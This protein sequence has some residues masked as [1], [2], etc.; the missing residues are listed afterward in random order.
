M[1]KLKAFA[2]DR[3]LFYKSELNKAIGMAAHVRQFDFHVCAATKRAAIERLAEV[4]IAAKSHNLK[5][6]TGNAVDALLAAGFLT[7]EGEVLATSYIPKLGENF[8]EITGKNEFHVVG[9]FR[10]PGD[11]GPRYGYRVERKAG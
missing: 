2:Y 11:D 3:A 1:A 7:R 5:V 9:T 10:E 8:V 6:P 4:G